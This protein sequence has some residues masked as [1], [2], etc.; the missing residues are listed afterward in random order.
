[1]NGFSVAGS[2]FGSYSSGGY[3]VFN[4]HNYTVRVETE[5]N[6]ITITLLKNSAFSITPYTPVVI[7]VVDIGITFG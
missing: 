4:D 5:K 2:I 6:A 3:D 1:V 7:E